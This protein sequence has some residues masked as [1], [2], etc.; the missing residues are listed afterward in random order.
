MNKDTISELYPMLQLL[1]LFKYLYSLLH[2]E[3]N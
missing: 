3:L 1:N 2:T